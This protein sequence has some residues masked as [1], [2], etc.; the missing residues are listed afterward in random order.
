MK[1]GETGTAHAGDAATGDARGGKGIGNTTNGKH[2]EPRG[3]QLGKHHGIGSVLHVSFEVG[4]LLKGIHAVIEV[5]SGVAVLLIKPNQLNRWIFAITRTE[6]AEDPNDFIANLLRHLGNSYNAQAQH[7]G[8]LYLISHGIING[9]IVLLLW[10][11]KLWAYPVMVAILCLFIAY[12]VIRFT[13]T[14]STFLV[15]VT[16]VDILFVFLTIAEYRRLRK[17]IT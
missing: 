16:I 11:R 1:P 12:Q 9:A 14:H 3:K 2:G 17:E 6:L 4:I 8:V 5:L 7:F 10:R 13:A 15:F